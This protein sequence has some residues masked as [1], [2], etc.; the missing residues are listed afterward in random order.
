MIYSQKQVDR[1]WNNVEVSEPDDCWNWKR[2]IS[3]GYGQVGLRVDDQSRI[4]KAHKVAWE[5][6]NKKPLS[7]Y[8]RAWHSCSNRLCCNPRHVKIAQ[9]YHVLET[10]PRSARGERHGNAKLTDRQVR[11]IKYRLNALTTTEIASAFAV[12]F[13]TIWDIRKG[14]TWRHI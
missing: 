6:H 13:N 10:K 12:S 7:R 2:S 11:I 3:N 5:I 4:L 9:P 14:L 8:V 1:F